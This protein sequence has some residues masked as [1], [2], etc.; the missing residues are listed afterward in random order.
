MLKHIEYEL[1]LHSQAIP[2]T[3]CCPH[4]TCSS[5]GLKT[6]SAWLSLF[7]SPFPF[8]PMENLPTSVVINC[9][10]GGLISKGKMR[11]IV[12]LYIFCRRNNNTLHKEKHGGGAQENTGIMSSIELD[13]SSG[14]QT[15][16]LLRGAMPREKRYILRLSL[17]ARNGD[18]GV[19]HCPEK[20]M[21]LWL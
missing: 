19:L 5:F 11:Q 15:R 20:C 1:P 3:D 7:L 10:V 16:G 6:P 14:P 9:Q 21:T 8:L 13:V 2:N 18:I 12:L 4:N 17:V